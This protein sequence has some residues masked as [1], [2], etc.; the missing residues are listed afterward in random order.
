[1]EKEKESSYICKDCAGEIGVVVDESRPYMWHICNR[2]G[3]GPKDLFKV[4]AETAELEEP[5]A[6]EQK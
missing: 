2:C 3:D 5:A 1:M 6:P 4:D